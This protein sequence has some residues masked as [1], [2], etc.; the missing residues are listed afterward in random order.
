MKNF[1][2]CSVTFPIVEATY[3]EF[4]LFWLETKNKAD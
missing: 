3:L 4:E 1:R 2:D